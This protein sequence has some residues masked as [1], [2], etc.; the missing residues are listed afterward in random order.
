LADV[1]EFNLLDYAMFIQVL[2]L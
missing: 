2:I 1:R